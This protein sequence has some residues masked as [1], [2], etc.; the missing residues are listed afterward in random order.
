MSL[1]IDKDLKTRYNV[2]IIRD[3]SIENLCHMSEIITIIEI[4]DF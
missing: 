1:F 4:I 3:M 2:V